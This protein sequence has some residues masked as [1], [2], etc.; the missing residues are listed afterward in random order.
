MAETVNLCVYLANI[1]RPGIWS[2]VRLNIFCG[3]DF[4]C[5]SHGSQ[6]TLG[7]ADLLP[8]VMCVSLIHS[9]QSLD[10]FLNITDF[11]VSLACRIKTHLAS[12][13]LDCPQIWIL[14]CS[15]IMITNCW[16][17]CHLLIH[18]FR[19]ARGWFCS[20]FWRTLTSVLRILAILNWDP[21]TVES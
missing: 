11:C 1:P 4:W 8:L 17:C 15:T 19:G 12:N 7:K 6:R 9:M 16:K 21:D 10:F 2:T 18:I 13:P 14:P 20:S 5:G 3:G